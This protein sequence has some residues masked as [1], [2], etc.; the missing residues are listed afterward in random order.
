MRNSAGQMTE[1]FH[2]LRLH[3]RHL[4][5]LALAHLSH[6]SVIGFCQFGS[7]FLDPVFQCGIEM[8]QSFLAFLQPP[9]RFAPFGDILR[10]AYQLDWLAARIATNL[11]LH[12]NPVQRTVR[13]E[14]P[15]LD[16][17]IG[18]IRNS[19]INGILLPLAIFRMNRSQQVL[20]L[21]R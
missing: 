9:P 7:P 15:I 13:P 3:Q 21:E 12:M 8:Q 11:A 10:Y 5:A 16:I 14:Y 6:Q 17:K 4:R 2:L 20:I 18:D 1:C 19:R